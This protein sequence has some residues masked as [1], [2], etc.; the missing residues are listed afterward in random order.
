MRSSRVLESCRINTRHF[1][2]RRGEVRFTFDISCSNSSP[3]LSLCLTIH[4]CSRLLLS[5]AGVSNSVSSAAVVSSALSVL[6]ATPA[7]SLSMYPPSYLHTFCK[8]AS[9]PRKRAHTSSLGAS[10]LDRKNGERSRPTYT[11]TYSHMH[12]VTL[13]N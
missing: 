2:G 10:H 3:H 1:T 7:V 6:P 13:T 12:P 11:H 9:N 5:Q 8:K 4:C